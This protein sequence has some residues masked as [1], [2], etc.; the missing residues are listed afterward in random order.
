M[1]FQTGAEIS[2]GSLIQYFSQKDRLLLFVSEIYLNA[3]QAFWDDYFSRELA[4]RTRDRILQ[5]F[6]ARLDYW[7]KDKI[8]FRFYLKMHYEN[9]YS[10]GRDFT[11]NIF[12]LRQKYL[13]GIIARG[14]ET[15]EIRRDR[16]ADEIFFVLSALTSKLDL[17]YRDILLSPR[18]K[19]DLGNLIEKVTSLLFD[20]IGG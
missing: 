1:K 12:R 3:Y 10:L 8:G 2:K 6:R 5:Y 11:D 20:G 18:D 14:M 4:V 16:N 17:T 9:D 13:R 15:G 19:T 7:D